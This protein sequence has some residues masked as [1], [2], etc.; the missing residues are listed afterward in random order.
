MLDDLVKYGSINSNLD[1][2][3]N[4]YQI[5]YNSKNIFYNYCNIYWN[6]IKYI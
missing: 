2:Y 3:Y 4:N 1:L 5:D 6:L